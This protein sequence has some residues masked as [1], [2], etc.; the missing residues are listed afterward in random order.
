MK[1]PDH[2]SDARPGISPRM[3]RARPDPTEFQMFG[4]VI[5]LLV[6]GLAVI[7]ILYAFLKSLH[8]L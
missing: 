1:K 6:V 3:M 4:G 2:D 8:W 7:G 5:G